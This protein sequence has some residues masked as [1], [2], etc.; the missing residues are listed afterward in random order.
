MKARAL[1]VVLAVGCG[2][3]AKH[4]AS[5]PAASGGPPPIKLTPA[6]ADTKP[7]APPAPPA[8]TIDS[9]ARGAA[10]MASLGDYHRAI[11]TANADAQAYFDQGMRLIYGFNHD[12]AARSFARAAQLDPKC[13]SCYWG[14]ALVLG[15]N[16]NV[17]ML[18]DRFPAAWDAVQKAKA[19]AAAA[20]PV[21]Q[22]LI[23]AL[24]KRYTGSEAKEPAAMQAQQQAYA[25]AMAEVAKKFPD[26]LDVQV[27]RAESIM[28]LNP[29][30][31][32]TP[33][34]KAAP[35]TDEIVATLEKVLKKD[36]KHP[37]ANHYYIHAIEASLHPDKAVPSA[38]RL[39]ALMPG[40][41][42]IVHMPAHIY[43]R[44]GRYA[45]ASASNKKAIEVD[46]EYMGR[47][48]NWG[49][50]SMYLVHNYG[51][52]SFSSSMLGRSAESLQAASDAAKNFP[53][54]MLEM[55]PG[56]DF[57][58][59][60]PLLAMVRFGKW[61]D[62]QKLK[63][64]D[65]KYPVLTA[66]WLH[67]QGIAAAATGKLEDAQKD[68]DELKAMHEKISPD[69]TTATN[70]VKDIVG[71]SELVLA[72]AIAQKKN[73]PDTA[74]AWADAVA[75]EDKLN[76]SEPNDWF[77]PVR[78]YQGAYL[79]GAKKYKEAEAVYRADLAKNPGNGWALFGLAQALRGEKKNAEAAKTEKQAAKAWGDADIKLTST[80]YL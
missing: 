2:S 32:W 70:S 73:D 56:M 10:L 75:A 46:Q 42:H 58:V 4:G 3:H 66:L 65:A 36:P 19:N 77:Y 41:G 76:Y 35:G 15:P 61:D 23:D 67:A 27:L 69:I 72:A 22:A 74:K 59:S 17:P 48:P 13:A 12:E 55:M 6:V 1:V 45:D 44:V 28:D 30:K 63:R 78:H 14:L 57:F 49:Y 31:L 71:V 5:P 39:A 34:G 47:A 20:T 51:F 9:I 50:Y 33:A 53:A 11:S 25:D 60:E 24:S 68:L 26:D 54:P 29:W 79:I 38:D 52:L 16:Y 8:L 18:P 64:P 37:G 62:I 43:Q 40:A 21:E 80:A 7:K